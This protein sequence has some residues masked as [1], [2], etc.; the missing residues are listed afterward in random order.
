MAIIGWDDSYPKE[1][2]NVDLEGDGAFI[3]QNSWGESFG[4]NGVFYVSYYDTN[5]GTHNVAYTKVE[6]TDNYDHI[7]Q[8]DLC[9]WVGQL[10]YN[11]NSMYGANVYTAEGA[12][13]LK[14]S[15]FLCDRKGLSVCTLCGAEF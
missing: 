4:E 12:E 1:N 6:S 9:G 8:S 3:C 10:G 14:S 15:V 13:S 11:K 7:Y 5:I 2:F